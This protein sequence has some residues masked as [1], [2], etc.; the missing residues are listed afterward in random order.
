MDAK[1]ILITGATDGIGKQTAIELAQMGH[2]LIL[3]GRDTKRGEALVSEISKHSGNDTICYANAD[4]CDFNEVVGLAEFIKSKF[5]KLDVI[6]NN[7]GVFETEKTILGNGLEKTFMV[8]HMAMFTLT[9]ILL[10]L[11]IKTPNSRIVNVSSMAQAS[12]MDFNNLNGEKHFDTYNAY[13]LS[14]LENVLFTYKLDRIIQGTETAVNCLH[15]G[16][17]ST[18]LLHAGWGAGGGNLKQGASTSIYLAVSEDVENISGKYF[19]NSQQKKSSPI[20]YDIKIQDR[21]WEISEKI[22]HQNV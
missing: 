12:T 18:K 13:A 1:T 6:I 10:P 22:M 4:F 20:S 7:A 8:N 17:I 14:K 9:N 15:P 16:I 21:L 3:H 2:T 11:I 5:N 19:V